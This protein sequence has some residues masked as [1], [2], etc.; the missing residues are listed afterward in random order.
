VQPRI[1][2]NTEVL[3]T[4]WGELLH[5][6]RTGESGAARILGMSLWEYFT[7]H[8]EVGA[9]FDRTMATAA[10][11]RL[12]AAIAAYDFGQF[13]TVV[14]VGGGNGALL[15]QILRTYDR[16]RGIAFDLPAVAE[17]AQ[18]N[19]A[20]VGLVDRCTAIGGSALEAV[21]AGGDLYV[22]S[23]LLTDM[24]DARVIAILRRCRDAMTHAGRLVLIERVMPTGGE[25][26]DAHKFWD[27]TTIEVTM[28]SFGGAAAGQVRT[29]EEFRALLEG[30]GLRLTRIIP[31]ASS[32]NVIEAGPR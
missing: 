3:Q 18:Q 30:G 5:T 22:L 19:I 7:T 24:D 15:I 4:L 21:P 20:I 28:R 11:N 9:L 26:T 17:R 13:G 12:G 1:I 32:L 16:P 14:D 2:F 27:M 29:A 10:H 6:L 23:N 8:P 25:P 31:T